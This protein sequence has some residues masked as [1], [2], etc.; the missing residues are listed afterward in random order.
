VSGQILVI[1][2]QQRLQRLFDGMAEAEARGVTVVAGLAGAADQLETARPGLILVQDRLSGLS[3]ELIVRHLRSRL[4][5]AEALIVLATES[6][7]TLDTVSDRLLVVDTSLPDLDILRQLERLVLR[8]PRPAEEVQ[9]EPELMPAPDEEFQPLV[10]PSVEVAVVAPEPLEDA[11]PAMSGQRLLDIVEESGDEKPPEVAAV[12]SRFEAELET[13]LARRE[14]TAASI[15]TE[16]GV[17]PVLSVAEML[18]ATAEPPVAAA[19]G[20]GRFITALAVLLALAGIIW[21]G[22]QPKSATP[23]PPAAKQPPTAVLPAPPAPAVAVPVRESTPVVPPVALAPPAVTAPTTKPVVPAVPPPRFI[24]AAQAV[25]DPAYGRDHAGWERF[26]APTLEFKLYR[27]QG[28][29]QAVQVVDR[30]GEGISPRLFTSALEELTK[31]RDYRTEER[32]VKGAYLVK[33][34][35][36]ASGGKII[37]YKDRQDQ[38]LHG[39]VIYFK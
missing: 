36:L 14:P 3:G 6:V 26:L 17:A 39:F 32:E 35:R 23:P 38:V 25:S 22:Q 33:K 21:F 30:A 7:D 11:E 4:G 5:D 19:K 18:T 37:L 20:S 10:V 9:P 28:K 13:E 29:L 31:V 8:L 12:V 15:A 24:S 34:G 1:A 2:E 27:E 16:S